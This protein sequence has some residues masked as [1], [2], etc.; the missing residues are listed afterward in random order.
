MRIATI[1]SALIG[2]QL[3]RTIF[4]PEGKPLLTVGVNLTPAILDSLR[5]RGYQSIYIKNELLPDLVIDDAVNEQTR[6]NA[7]VTVRKT[8]EKL[9]HGGEV[10]F[11]QI[12]KIV[13]RIMDE[14]AEASDLV[15]SLSTLRS[16]DE[17]TFQHSV[18]VCIICLLLGEALHYS[19]DD[20]HKL[21]VG[22]ILHDVGKIF[23]AD[24]VQK[25]DKLTTEE[26]ERMKTHPQTG[27]DTL[28]SNFEINL[29]SAHVAFQHH[30]RLDGSGYPRG[31]RGSEIHEFGRIG[32]VA[33][34]YDALI[35]D[36]SYRPRMDPILVAEHLLSRA[37]AHLDPELV[38]KLL[39]RVAAIPTGS[40]I[41]LSTRQLAVVTAQVRGAA[42]TPI[43]QV[44][45]DA[46]Y[47]L[48]E[49]YDLNLAE[50]PEV[51]VK[52]LLEEYPPRV[53]E[54]MQARNARDKAA[55]LR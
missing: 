27:F 46:D 36:R 55:S 11:K 52:A 37:G 41:V 19:R 16:V 29:L 17:Y 33:D 35:S 51:S 18:N 4:T 31:L 14:M 12:S 1:S 21:G 39:A 9:S 50:Q 34:V 32:A 13:D 45:T 47:N 6:V 3:A 26:W 8:M 22:G 15:F 43:I 42:R 30:E 20:L 48:I 38:K 5:K 53:Q 49:P 2:K 28:R 10:E 44:V 24:L 54:Q 23:V 25:P 40:I 7:E